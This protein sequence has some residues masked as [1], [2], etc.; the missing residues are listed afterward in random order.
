MQNSQL[1]PQPAWRDLALW[2]RHAAFHRAQPPARRI[3]AWTI[4]TLYAAFLFGFPPL[5]WFTWHQWDF[6]HTA[7]IVSC[8]VP[9][10][11][12][13]LAVKARQRHEDGEPLLRISEEQISS[14]SEGYQA[15]RI[16]LYNRPRPVKI[17]D[18]ALRLAVLGILALIFRAHIGGN[19]YFWFLC[20]ELA[21]RVLLMMKRPARFSTRSA[22][23]PA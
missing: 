11:W 15:W 22:V 20:A 16:R 17:A 1:S 8:L 5:V 14:T 10:Y 4:L 3:A 9:V 13:F 6:C 7:H 2:A 21:L 18:I 19:G 23:E 12:L